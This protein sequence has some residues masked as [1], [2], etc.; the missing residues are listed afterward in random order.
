MSAVVL[1]DVVPNIFFGVVGVG[2]RTVEFTIFSLSSW[3][4]VVSTFR[5]GVVGV[6]CLPYCSNRVTALPTATPL[7]ILSGDRKGDGGGIV[8]AAGSSIIALG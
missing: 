2:L 1:L 8:F 5:F 4:I 7:S 6:L 3:A